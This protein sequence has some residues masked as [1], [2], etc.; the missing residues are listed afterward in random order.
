[1]QTS[2][3]R[4]AALSKRRGVKRQCQGE[5]CGTP[6]YDLN[7][8]PIACP[9]C[10]A[11]YVPPPVVE[12]KKSDY[13]RRPTYKLIKEVE[14]PDLPVAEA[15]SEDDEAGIEIEADDDGDKVDNLLEVDDDETTPDEIVDPSIVKDEPV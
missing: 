10:G 12:F 2:L 14:K 6:F 11:A 1:M 7:R 3:E 4:I 13:G 9:N 8:E 5:D 15:A